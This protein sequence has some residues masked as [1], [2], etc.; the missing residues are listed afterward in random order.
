MSKK[1]I[2]QLP[3]LLETFEEL[4]T[5][6][7]DMLLPLSVQSDT[8]TE[9]VGKS[10]KDVTVSHLHRF[11]FGDF[12]ISIV[13][14]PGRS[15]LT[16]APSVL[17]ARICLDKTESLFFL[18]PYDVIPYINQSDLICRYFPYIESAERLKSCYH[19][20][21]ESLVPYL[22]DFTRIATDSKELTKTYD[23]LRG[24]MVRCYGNNIFMPSN[25][26]EEFDSTM[27]AYRFY[28]FTRWRSSFFCSNEYNQF[29]I[30]NYNALTML[31]ARRAV[32]D[33]FRHLALSVPG[34]NQA[35][36]KPVRDTSASLPA[37][38]KASKR[39]TSFSLLLIATL[40]GLPV[41][42]ILFGILYFGIAAILGAN[43]EFYTSF[44][45][46]AFLNNYNL[47]LLASIA[48]SFS[49]ASIL[50]RIFAKQRYLDYRPYQLML[51]K[52]PQHTFPGKLKK[53]I[54]FLA[55]IVIALSA[56][57]G[58][59][60]KENTVTVPTG[61]LPFSNEHL[62]YDD[63]ETVYKYERKDGSFYYVFSLNDG[64]ESFSLES[65]MSYYEYSYVSEKL[66]PIFEKHGITVE[67]PPVNKPS[68]TTSS[69][70]TATTAPD[71]IAPETTPNTTPPGKDNATVQDNQTPMI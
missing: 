47:I 1:K 16:A 63:I 14:T 27:L 31:T 36:V 25:K 59:M 23:N 42:S 56:S 17:E 9:K 60:F 24:E 49:T 39:A 5:L 64:T 11:D 67:K 66:E 50:L 2:N 28:H 18:T 38:M 53:I 54:L 33:Y 45:I 32:P 4:K 35:P 34:L 52:N 7:D 8:L 62:E 65:V 51:K 15:S 55:I 6:G 21:V 30:G 57:R 19:D 69:D 58:V 48:L 29:L 40:V 68:S 70:T 43:T 3:D 46:T 41:L 22:N 71:T 13:Y 12:F 20:L 26:G 61:Y 37:M 10:Q 44:T